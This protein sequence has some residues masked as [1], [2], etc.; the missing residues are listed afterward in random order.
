MMK[1]IASII[2]LI[3]LWAQLNAQPDAI[4]NLIALHNDYDNE[5]LLNWTYPGPETLSTNGFFEIQKSTDYFIDWSTGTPGNLV[6][7]SDYYNYFYLRKGDKVSYTVT[8]LN[9][10][11]TYYFRVWTNIIYSSYSAYSDISNLAYNV[12]ELHVDITSPS[13][14]NDLSAIFITP[15][16]I[17][18]NSRNMSIN[19]MLYDRGKLT[20]TATGDDG[21]VGKAHHYEVRITTNPYFD[22]VNKWEE[23]T[24]V[25]YIFYYGNQIA[26]PGEKEEIEIGLYNS[27]TNYIAVKV[28]DEYNNLSGI[29]NIA[30]CDTHYTFPP[31]WWRWS[32]NFIDPLKGEK[33]R[34][35][36]H[37]SVP[38][39]VKVNIYTITGELV[40]T[41]LNED[42]IEGDYY[43][44]W[45]GTNTDGEIVANGL[46]VEKAQIYDHT[47]T[48]KIIV[49]KKR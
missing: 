45:D 30:K 29:S 25:D 19:S 2:A 11:T 40:N 32:K 1:K 5:I 38:G 46:Y 13:A 22:W 27:C 9:E 8:G 35:D 17:D 48:G 18:Y 34:L 20:F 49:F 37:V 28:S 36:Y 43:T 47:Y 42:S 23:A 10:S 41:L 33:A 12:V 21:M 39:H 26:S 31:P 4:T 15:P 14:V 7:R 44:E 24:L 3:S 16:T 6:K